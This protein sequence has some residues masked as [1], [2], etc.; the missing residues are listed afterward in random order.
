MSLSSVVH[1]GS[2]DHER[3]S[4]QREVLAVT[5]AEVS[6]REV[7]KMDLSGRDVLTWCPAY[8]HEL[9][10]SC[11]RGSRAICFFHHTEQWVLRD[12]SVV[13]GVCMNSTMQ[14]ELRSICRDKPVYL[15]KV[16]GAE[17]ARHHA[18]R[19]HPS[20]KIR[21]LVTGMGNAALSAEEMRACPDGASSLRKSPELLLSIADRL[22]PAHYAFVFIGPDWQPYATALQERG[23]TVIA[24]GLVPDPLQYRYLG[25]GDIYLMLSRLEG[26]PLPLLETMGLGMWPICTPTGMAPDIIRHGENGFIVSPFDG[27][28]GDQIADEVSRLIRTLD[29]GTL[30]AARG[31]IRES[32]ADRTWPNFK[33]EMEQIMRQVFGGD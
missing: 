32:T 18:R 6:Q 29:R 7:L 24:P 14:R 28:N 4:I 17:N 25:E 23:W 3:W 22:D 26:G 9:P 33:R 8:W 10:E 27:K 11:R 1:L 20:D 2:R 15:A 31:P 16:G 21:F 19:E 13:A 5:D 30:H 12:P